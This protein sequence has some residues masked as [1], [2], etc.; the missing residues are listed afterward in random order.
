MR[1][2]NWTTLAAI[3]ACLS[4]SAWADD[5]GRNNNGNGNGNN[6]SNGFESGLI[7]S[8]PS[9]TVGG[10]AS[11]GVAWVVAGSDVSISGDGRLRVEVSGLLIANVTGV[12]ANLV[13]TTG[14]V[15]M[16][17]ASLVCGGSGG[18]VVASSDGA[19][20]SAAGNANIDAM[21]TVPTTGCMAPVVLIRVFTSSA[22][23]GSQ[24]GVFIALTGFNAGA[25]ANHDDNNGNNG[26]HDH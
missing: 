22:P 23:T 7:G 21:V 24:L 4:I 11:G 6:G 25:N 19:P 15:T 5:H 1:V 2:R 10:V 26:G 8:V 20:L 17:G 13:G 3:A 12:P 16:V 9:T 14:P 18:T